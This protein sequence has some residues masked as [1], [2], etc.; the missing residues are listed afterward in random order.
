MV[1]ENSKRAGDDTFFAGP[2]DMEDKGHSQCLRDP[3]WDDLRFELVL[4][5]RQ[6]LLP[7]EWV[8]SQDEGGSGSIGYHATRHH[9]WGRPRQVLRYADSDLYPGGIG[10]CSSSSDLNGMPQLS[11]N[12]WMLK[13]LG[14]DLHVHA[15]L[16]LPSDPLVEGQRSLDSGVSEDQ[17]QLSSA[18]APEEEEAQQRRRLHEEIVRHLSDQHDAIR[19]EIVNRNERM[20][21]L[22]SE[23]KAKTKEFTAWVEARCGEEGGGNGRHFEGK[24]V[25]EGEDKVLEKVFQKVDQAP[26][27]DFLD[28]ITGAEEE[29]TTVTVEDWSQERVTVNSAELS[30]HDTSPAS[31]DAAKS[32]EE[33]DFINNHTHA[34]GAIPKGSAEQQATCLHG[35]GNGT[36]VSEQGRCMSWVDNVDTSV[37]GDAE[38]AADVAGFGGQQ[39]EQADFE[40]RAPSPSSCTRPPSAVMY[41]DP[42]THKP[43]PKAQRQQAL[44]SLA[45]S[46]AAANSG[47][48]GAL[49]EADRILALSSQVRTCECTCHVPAI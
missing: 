4:R 38:T 27:I 15:A 30:A 46:T 3:V 19:K 49:E 10:V 1:A 5:R 14:S 47:L 48:S 41:M 29:V 23:F 2:Y 44:E 28:Q 8:P 18:G 26:R 6:Q 45:Q 12:E 9:G 31:V 43:K 24:Q 17:V 21:E 7:P 34:R 16:S 25:S 33:A 32:E 37:A 36:C 20:N 11:K 42:D 40:A 13:A 22:E 35:A 39:E